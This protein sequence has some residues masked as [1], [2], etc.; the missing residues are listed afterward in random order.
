MSKLAFLVESGKT[1]AMN[2]RGV[3]IQPETDGVLVKQ[4]GLSNKVVVKPRG[5]NYTHPFKLKGGKQVFVHA[6]STVVIGNHSF[7]VVA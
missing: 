6:G 3:D 1:A 2:F 4:T 7:S 5:K